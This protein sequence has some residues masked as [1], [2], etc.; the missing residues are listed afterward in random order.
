MNLYTYKRISTKDQ[1]KGSGLEQQITESN[2]EFV[3]DKFSLKQVITLE[4]GVGL[5]GFHAKHLEEGEALREFIDGCKAGVIPEGSILLVYSL[6]RLS[7]MTGL[8]AITDVY[9][10]IVTNKVKIYTLAENQ[11]FDDSDMSQL[12]ATLLFQ[13]SHNESK[14][15]SQRVTGS[16]LTA[17]QKYQ[18]EGVRTPKLTKAPFW[19]DNDTC[20]VNECVGAVKAIVAW[21]IEG[22]GYNAITTRLQEQYPKKTSRADSKTSNFWEQNKVHKVLNNIDMLLGHKSVSV[23]GETYTLKNYYPSVITSQQAIELKR[24]QGTFRTPSINVNKLKSLTKI[25]CGTCGYPLNFAKKGNGHFYYFCSGAA[26]K[27]SSCARNYVS[28]DMV[29]RWIFL[30]A[31]DAIQHYKSKPIDNTEEVASLKLSIN[32]L[33]TSLND[34]SERYK[35]TKSV[36]VLDLIE[37]SENELQEAIEALSKL[38]FTSVTNIPSLE[39][40]VKLYQDFDSNRKVIKDLFSRV[41]DKAS[42]KRVPM[43]NL[44]TGWKW[45]LELS[46]LGEEYLYK[47]NDA[48][49]PE[50]STIAKDKLQHSF[51]ALYALGQLVKEG[52][53]H[54]L[55]KGTARKKE[56]IDMAQE[57]QSII[58]EAGSY[59]MNLN[60]L[61][62]L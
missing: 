16:I 49:R 5:S 31:I 57:M 30:M 1:I 12:F 3:Q 15:K 54:E 62:T 4:S 20:E 22:V 9:A 32:S 34:L 23:L 50:Y 42:L 36:V 52:Y 41:V 28:T 11:L 53:Y 55:L 47:Y 40:M 37:T 18:K 35:R 45:E 7:R 25:K 46:L 59:S 24:L 58:K 8:T 26:K 17:V 6:D 13:R 38:E 51:I 33:Q 43:D 14:T 21:R 48:L 44:T 60:L 27:K 39:D 2:I 29:D 19:I 10:P 56:Y 61:K